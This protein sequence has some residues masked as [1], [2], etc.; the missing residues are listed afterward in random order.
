MQDKLVQ[1]IEHFGI[2]N[3]QRKL[4]EEVFELQSAITTHE[5][6]LSNE[7][8]IPL[9]YIVGTKEHI[10]EELSDVLII[11]NQFVRYYGLDYKDIEKTINDKVDR[12][13]KRIEEGY[14][15]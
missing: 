9:N 14:Y 11:L 12:T 10:T 6:A 1:I 13:L 4:M 2:E 5:M 8:E 3:Q 7:Y 15:K